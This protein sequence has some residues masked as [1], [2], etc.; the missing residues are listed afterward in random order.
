MA[1]RRSTWQKAAVKDA[2]TKADVFISAQDL[3]KTLSQ[4]NQKVG[5]TTVYRAL[6]ELADTGEA[7]QLTTSDGEM[8]YRVCHSPLHHHH[9][10]CRSCGKAVEVKFAATEGWAEKL[11][12]EHGFSDVTHSIEIFGICASCGEN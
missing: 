7:D 2:L 3:H 9:L 5:L 12:A 11:A 6:S 1:E 10:S 4:E 8:R